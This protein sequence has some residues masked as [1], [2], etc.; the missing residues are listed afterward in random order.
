MDRAINAARNRPT[1]RQVMRS[2][3]I[4]AGGADA[5]VDAAAGATTATPSI[6]KE[7]QSTLRLPTARQKSKPL[8]SPLKGPPHRSTAIPSIPARP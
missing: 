1:K 5:G 2:A 7:A 4:A 3:V 8:V 6:P